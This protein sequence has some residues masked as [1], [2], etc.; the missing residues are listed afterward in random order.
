VGSTTEV[1]PDGSAIICNFTELKRY[2]DKTCIVKVD[3]HECIKKD[4]VVYYAEA[5]H[6]E[7]EMQIEALERQIASRKE[8]LSPELLARFK[9]GAL[10]SPHTPDYIKDLLK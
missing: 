3:E 8:P 7:T 1:L 2:S 10:D 6:C 9:R 5:Y 4:S